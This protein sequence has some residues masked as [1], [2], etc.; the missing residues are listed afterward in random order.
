[1]K[2]SDILK[3]KDG[4]NGLEVEGK[5]TKIFKPEDKQIKSGPRAGESFKVQNLYLEGDG[6]GVYVSQTGSFIDTQTWLDKYVILDNVK[7]VEYRNKKGEQVKSLQSKG[8]IVDTSAKKEEPLMEV[9]NIDSKP[10]PAP[11]VWD[12]KERKELRKTLFNSALMTLYPIL[13]S[14]TFG[15]NGDHLTTE[16]ILQEVKTVADFGF[17]F[18]YSPLEEEIVKEKEDDISIPF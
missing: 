11:T 16:A 7:V 10:M 8:N 12:L 9:E 3:F 13:S 6:Q 5:L 18:T 14:R 2:L 17:N 15:E 4:V 1:M